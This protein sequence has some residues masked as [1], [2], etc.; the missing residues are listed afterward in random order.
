MLMN[1]L[2]VVV[3]LVMFSVLVA[4]HELGHYLFARK[5]K[6]G[7]SEFS[8]GMGHQIKT[9]ARRKYMSSDGEEKETLF[10]V[11]AIPIGGFVKIV[12][13]EPNE[14]GTESNDP[15]GFYKKSPWQR[16]AVLLAGPVFS[17]AFGWLVLVAV[18][19]ATGID[20]PNNIVEVIGKN[21]PAD[22]AG[23]EKG[24][25]ILSIDDHKIKDGKE[26]ISWIRKSDGKSIILKVDRKSQLLTVTLKPVLSAEERPTYDEDGFP[27]GE[28][29][30]QPQVGIG[31]GADHI[32][33]GMS[34][35]ISEASD[36]PIQQVSAM[37]KKFLHPQVLLNSST[38]AVGMVAITNQAVQSG[39][40]TVFLLCGMISISL[41]IFNLL[42]I[43]PLDGGQ[44]FLAL[45]EVFRGGKKV[46]FRVQTRFVIVGLI[47]MAGIFAF[48]I[49][50]DMFQYVLPGK[51]NLL[52]H[53]KPFE[54]KGDNN[55]PDT[56]SPS[57][58]APVK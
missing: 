52:H 51:E 20:I 2:T 39:L 46:S 8:I 42:P 13:M 41:G 6:M 26:A 57:N 19:A 1:L 34:G 56:N 29:K 21:L 7:V 36:F 49:Y 43:V 38:G 58:N 27:T 55:S 23:L 3:F 33:P 47:F 31:F 30:R 54:V 15:D 5:F 45:V 24:D 35:A 14:D 48:R 28:F 44:I 10:N 17:L 4:V 16:I 18:F 25:R 40:S 50:K 11:R 9:W 12:G 37:A 22:T 32:Y 53:A